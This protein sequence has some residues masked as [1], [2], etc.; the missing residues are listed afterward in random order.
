MTAS[1]TAR[2]RFGSG[3]HLI[4]DNC[5]IITG[6]GHSHFPLGYLEIKDGHISEIG[7]GRYEHAPPDEAILFDAQGA[8]TLPGVIN[9]HA[10][11]CMSGPLMPSGSISSRDHDIEYQKNRHLLGGTTTLLN[12]CGFSLS[13]SRAER[14]HP[15][16]VRW[17]SAHTPA[18]KAAA[19]AVDG[20]GLLA[21][22]LSASITTAI[23]QGAVGLGEGGGGQTLG[24]GAQ[25]Y[26]FIP[27][28]I[29]KHTGVSLDAHTAG[30]LKNMLF[31][32]D[33][34]GKDR[35]PWSDFVTLCE[36]LGLVETHD[37]H[38]IAAVMSST[39][40]P[41]VGKALK[42][43]EELAHWSS[44]TGLPA[45]LHTAAPSARAV[46]DLAQKYPEA[47]LIAAHCNH[48]SFTPQESVQLATELK[49]LGVAIEACTLDTITTRWRNS[50]DNL[51]ALVNAGLV[52]ILSTD[53]AG[54]HWDGLLEAI[55]RIVRLG[56]MAMAE[57]VALA[58]GNVARL[59]PDFADRGQL[60]IGKRADVVIADS[61]NLGRVRHVLIGGKI[62]VRDGI[63]VG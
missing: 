52:D 18:S 7:S 21:E 32:R 56:Q 16:D 1:R 6:D 60:T 40:L 51:D 11:G 48:P 4:I 44:K 5:A 54:G 38:S 43:L 13:R 17:T 28:A 8:M 59:F 31:G 41:S 34:M 14:T 50:A 29:L 61:R 55:H 12:V 63:V 37:A 30:R 58:T 24:G 22:H 57:A 33:L 25:D 10:H 36:Q 35:A 62:V 45:L 47:C 53:Y 9:A 27:A 49:S 20:T 2:P 3:S 46:V 23:E 39:V 19:L 15:I 26:K 42:G